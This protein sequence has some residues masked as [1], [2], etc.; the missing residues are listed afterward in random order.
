MPNSYYSPDTEHVSLVFS[1]PFPQE[2]L[3]IMG[4]GRGDLS[5]H[6]L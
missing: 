4:S 1:I 2:V 5:L 3:F 6:P